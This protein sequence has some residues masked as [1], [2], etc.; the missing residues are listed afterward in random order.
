MIS[1]IELSHVED[2]MLEFD[3]TGR[4]EVLKKYKFKPATGYLARHKGKFYDPKAIVGIGHLHATGEPLNSQQFVTDVARR[5]LKA[6]DVQVLEFNG[7]WWVNQGETF[8]QQST[9]GYLWASKAA[10]NGRTPRHWSDVS[11]MQPGQTIIHYA[12]GAIV[13]IGT[14]AGKP[15]VAPNPGHSDSEPGYVCPVDYRVLDDPIPRSQIPS[16]LDSANPFDINGKVKQAY[17]IRIDDNDVPPFLE[18]LDKC[19]PTLFNSRPTH[20]SRYSVPTISGPDTLS[21]PI[22]ETLLTFKNVILEGVPGTGKTYALNKIAQNWLDRTGRELQQ[23]NGQDFATIVMHPSSSYE[24]FVEGLRP[25]RGGRS[26]GFF[27]EESGQTSGFAISDGFFVDVCKKAVASPNK[28]VL[29]LVDELNRCN[30]PSVFGDLMLTIEA[31]KR[32]TYIGDSSSRAVRA[33]MWDASTTAQLPYSG[34]TFFVP[35]NVYVVAT[36]NTTDRSVAPLDAALRRRFAFLR[37]E[38]QMTELLVPES[39]SSEIRDVF[40]RGTA[41]ISRVNDLALRTLLGPDAILGH[42]YFHAISAELGSDSLA[43]PL[44]MIVRH[45]RFTILPQLIDSVR[46]FN[47]EEILDPRTRRVWFAHHPELAGPEQ[48]SAI[49][50]LQQF[51][52]HL[53][54]DL[55]MKIAVE[56]TGLA[57]GARVIDA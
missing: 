20:P 8:A 35:D 9:G 30:I 31:S 29:V 38:P 40:Q 21:D 25:S 45:W 3:S 50:A 18:F 28:D 48:T 14:V 57:R 4:I 36:T 54:E 15:G 10:G 46:A 32:A 51:D 22:L 43:D 33:S 11:R 53:E 1:D 7:L 56:G 44:A 2:A 47:A 34:R 13:A 42:S 24:D 37:L 49:E 5:R 41:A 23:F 6:L 19:I 26:P 52:L 12:R 17:L 55:Q 16:E 27:D 39:T